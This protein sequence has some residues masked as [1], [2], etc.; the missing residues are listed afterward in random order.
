MA[1]LYMVGTPIG[2]L[3]DISLRALETL[4]SV[5]LIACEDTRHTLKLLTHYQIKV[6]LI[7]CR[8]ANESFAADKVIAALDQGLN[9]AFTSDAGSPGISDPG[10]V[11]ARKASSAGHT[12][13]PIPGPSAFASLISV[14]GGSFKTVIFEGF[15]SPKSGRRK[16]RVKELLD[17]GAA[18]V[19]YESPFRVIK[20]FE[21]LA[22]LDTERFVCIGREMTKIHEEYLRGSAGELLRM[23]TERQETKQQSLLG[24]FSVFV[25][26]QK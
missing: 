9:A 21:D 25:A 2:N 12:V 6:K 14:A 4:K 19:V 7:S 5:D 1:T 10:S 15:L 20:L 13:I 16:S 24:E 18:F 3:A 23:L 17:S 8:S 26:G 11:L 22:D